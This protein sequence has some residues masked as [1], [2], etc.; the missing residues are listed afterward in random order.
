MYS[1]EDM[2]ALLG[3]VKD[4]DSPI[5][6]VEVDEDT[7]VRDTSDQSDVAASDAGSESI[8]TA[9][10]KGSARQKELRQ[11]V[12]TQALAKQREAARA[13]QAS[14]KQA[15]AEHRR[16][17]EEVNKYE[18]RLE[19]IER[20]FRRLLGVVRVKPL[21]RDRF[22]N[23]IWWFDGTGSGSLVGSGGVAQ[24][25]TGRVFIQGPSEFDMELLNQRKDEDIDERR[26][27]EEG[28]E[29]MLGS[30]NWAVYS[31]IE[32]VRIFMLSLP[33]T[34]PALA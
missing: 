25:G 16:L 1:T 27:E 19:G 32:E 22:F 12:Q 18:R 15:M 17:D 4:A 8:S 34:D 5:P 13:K 3:D 7:V 9:S 33:I 28:E 31:D 29:G 30:G 21:G 11:K 14:A 10:K 24:Y 6:N 26:R 20:D 23:R 2:N